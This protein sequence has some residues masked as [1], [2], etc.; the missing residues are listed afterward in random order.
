MDENI[1]VSGK[2]K[3]KYIWSM[4]E[5]ACVNGK[6]VYIACVPGNG[7]KVSRSKY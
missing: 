2:K 3:K 6:N 4:S 5:D 1:C 7:E